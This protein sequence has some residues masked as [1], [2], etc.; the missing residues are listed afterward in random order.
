VK[1]IL[2]GIL[3]AALLTAARADDTPPTEPA[4]QAKPALEV[5]PQRMGYDFDHPEIL[6]RQRL[7]GLAHGLSML[8]AACLDLPE[9]STPIQNAYAAWHAEQAR[10]I[11]TLVLDLARHYF[12]PRAAE[13]R[14][15]DLALALNLN[16]SIHPALGQVSLQDACASLPQAIARPRYQFDKLLAE[17]DASATKPPV[18][19]AE[20][21]A[22]APEKP[23]HSTAEDPVAGTIQSASVAVES[24]DPKPKQPNE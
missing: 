5:P 21:T 20:P 14:W 18:P 6:I 10:A 11:E 24:A 7:F 16:D 2:A 19:A 12:G 13:A 1:R 22:T 17:A 9:H 23:L 8:A 3:L 4:A 15:Q